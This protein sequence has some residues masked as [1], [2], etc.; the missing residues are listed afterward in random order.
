MISNCQDLIRDFVQKGFKA[1]I[2]PR[3]VRFICMGCVE[4]FYCYNLGITVVIMFEYS[5][6]IFPKIELYG[7]VF[8]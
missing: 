3:P 6:F 2:L 4:I 8:D 5:V 1:K 7:C